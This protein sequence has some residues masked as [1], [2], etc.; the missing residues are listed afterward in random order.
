[1][2]AEKYLPHIEKLTR[3]PD[4]SEFAIEV[5]NKAKLL[6][7]GVITQEEFNDGNYLVVFNSEFD[8]TKLAKNSINYIKR[9]IAND[10]IQ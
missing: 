2:I 1:M 8:H 9:M 5:Y 7:D 10:S 3:N 4:V 6:I